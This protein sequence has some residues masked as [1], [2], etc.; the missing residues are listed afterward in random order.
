MAI[1][2]GK[3][4]PLSLAMI[5]LLNVKPKLKPYPERLVSGRDDEGE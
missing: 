5:F 3:S 4:C 1:V 2:R